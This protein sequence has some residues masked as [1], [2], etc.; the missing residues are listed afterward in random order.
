MY[1]EKYT[2]LCVF[3]FALQTLYILLQNVDHTNNM[4]P[5]SMPA[6]IGYN[7]DYSGLLNG[8]IH[9]LGWARSRHD[10]DLFR[11]QYGIFHNS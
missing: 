9:A 1:L 10:M 5:K 2:Y 7:I 4:K 11:P 8:L 3:R 6:F